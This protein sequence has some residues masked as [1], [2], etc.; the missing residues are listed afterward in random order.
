MTWDFNPEDHVDG[1]H[2]TE[3]ITA[4]D[5]GDRHHMTTISATPE[6]FP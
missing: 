5:H 3:S 6:S 4:E 1:R 2:V